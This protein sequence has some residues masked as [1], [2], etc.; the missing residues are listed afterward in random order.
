MEK[1]AGDKA[2]IN[3]FICVPNSN[4]PQG[5]AICSHEGVQDIKGRKTDLTAA[6]S[7][8]TFGQVQSTQVVAFDSR[9]Y[10]NTYEKAILRKFTHLKQLAKLQWVPCLL[11]LQLKKADWKYVRK[12]RERDVKIQWHERALNSSKFISQRERKEA[13]IK[14]YLDEQYIQQPWVKTLNNTQHSHKQPD[15][16]NFF[17]N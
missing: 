17:L 9:K 4:F 15:S 6:G 8:N 10:E 12:P 11:Q 16:V 2:V 5:Q 13:D 1:C 14:S 7:T 3:F